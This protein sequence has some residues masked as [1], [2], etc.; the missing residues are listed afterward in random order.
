M[1]GIQRAIVRLVALLIFG[2]IATSMWHVSHE[3]SRYDGAVMAWTL[4]GLMGAINAVAAWSFLEVKSSR[5]ISGIIAVFVSAVSIWLQLRFYQHR[6]ALD[7]D[8]YIYG[9]WAPIMEI[10]LG[11]LF[12][13]LTM[14]VQVVQPERSGKTSVLN[15]IGLAVAERI[16][17]VSP[18]IQPNTVPVQPEPLN[19]Q[20]VPV[21]PVQNGDLNVINER[22]G[23]EKAAAVEKMLTYYRTHPFASHDEVG[24]I[25]GRSKPTISAYLGE[26]EKTGVVHRNG[27]GVEVL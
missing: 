8:A 12:A 1:T 20:S 3:M 7:V 19:V 17:T 16:R 21:Q 2:A 27:N 25:I 6:G 10:G 22:R 13:R 5:W 18:N 24:K 11:A 9:S 14:N 26:L 23:D 4:G 15:I